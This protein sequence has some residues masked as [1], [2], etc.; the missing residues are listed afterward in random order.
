MP[1]IKYFGSILFKKQCCQQ[2]LVEA[3]IQIIFIFCTTI[4]SIHTDNVILSSD[5]YV[6]CVIHSDSPVT[7]LAHLSSPHLANEN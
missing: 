6:Q 5:T 3:A 1:A 7:T 4:Y 2:F